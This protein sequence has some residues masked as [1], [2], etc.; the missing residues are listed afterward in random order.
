MATLLVGNS[1]RI[2]TCLNCNN[3]RRLLTGYICGACSGTGVVDIGRCTSL[4][5]AIRKLPNGA[6]QSWEPDPETECQPTDALCGSW[7]KVEV[8]RDRL[9]KG[10]PL[11]HP[12]DNPRMVEIDG[13]VP[14]L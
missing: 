7:D 8:L 2:A 10:Q 4:N 13:P 11:F 5:D 1:S 3:G 12:Q 9:E 14:P 6:S